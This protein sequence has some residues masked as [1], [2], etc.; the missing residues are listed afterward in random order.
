MRTLLLLATATA[1][2]LKGATHIQLAGCNADCG[3]LEVKLP[4]D[5]AWR[6]VTSNNW[7]R[8]DAIK[9]CA[10]L[11]FDE[12]ASISSPFAAAGA[13]GDRAV[14]GF[15]GSV[16][17]CVGGE[18]TMPAVGV[19]CRARGPPT[20][21]AAAMAR[22]DAWA[23][24]RT[25][26]LRAALSVSGEGNATLS[27]LTVSVDAIEAAR[28]LPFAVADRLAAVKAQKHTIEFLER[29][30]RAAAALQRLQARGLLEVTPLGIVMREGTSVHEA[31]L[32]YE[33]YLASDPNGDVHFEIDG[34]RRLAP[35]PTSDDAVRALRRDG[36][37][38]IDDWKFLTDSIEKK[39]TRSL[40]GSRKILSSTSNGRVATAR[41]RDTRLERFFRSIDDI[42]SGYLGDAQL[43]GYKVVRIDTTTANDTESYVAGLWHHD[44]V[45]N[46]L[47][48]F[49][50]LHDVDC[51]EGHPTEVAVGSHLLNYY[52]TDAMGASRFSDEYVR[53]HYVVEKLCGPK[54]GGFVVDTHTLHRGAV[55]GSLPRTV[56]VGE[57]H[58]VG[59]CAAMDAL[60]LGLPCPSGDQ[61]LV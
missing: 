4:D 24:L 34:R 46:R 58:A 38:R 2:F 20:D 13:T 32:A 37:V 9:T 22:V 47:K 19:A 6:A 35:A 1:E 8:G 54:G 53:D 7:T 25:A 14:L 33:A 27:E 31:E 44:R 57:Y 36:I 61:F 48:A 49:V 15:D 42:A 50:F 56:V 55:E 21:T 10:R 40:H 41:Y 39:A 16:R 52:R 45:G 23:P 3:R 18:C 59:K 30:P 5:D 28:A 11:G 12:V 17:S 26:R 60:G 29:H 51:D 43:S